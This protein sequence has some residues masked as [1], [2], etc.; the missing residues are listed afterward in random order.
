MSTPKH[1]VVQAIKVVNE[2]FGDIAELIDWTDT[3]EGYAIMVHGG[4]AVDISMDGTVH[5]ALPKGTYL[6]AIN[7]ESMRLVRA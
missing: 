1:M 7:N 3:D 2:Q 5:G 6:E 4:Y